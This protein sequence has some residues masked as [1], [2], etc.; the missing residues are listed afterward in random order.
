MLVTSPEK[1]GGFFPPHLSHQSGLDVDIG[2]YLNRG[3]NPNSF[4]H[5]NRRTMDTARTWTLIEEFLRT[6]NVQYIF[7]DRYLIPLLRRYAAE[8]GRMTPAQERRWFGGGGIIRHLKGHADH[9]HI[10]IRAPESS[11]AVARLEN[12]IGGKPYAA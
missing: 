1:N 7:S 12:E 5:T 2:Y 4:R 11:A 9:L 6:K 10:R 3:H 8:N